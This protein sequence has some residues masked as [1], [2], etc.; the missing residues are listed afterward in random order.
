[1]F[2]SVLNKHRR[3][4]PG[5]QNEHASAEVL[6]VCTTVQCPS[7]I[8]FVPCC[9]LEFPGLCLTL[10]W[11]LTLGQPCS[12]SVM[13][14]TAKLADS[15]GGTAAW[16]PTY[17]GQAKYVWSRLTICITDIFHV[18][19]CVV[20]FWPAHH[21]LQHSVHMPAQHNH[22]ASTP[23][24]YQQTT[25]GLKGQGPVELGD[26]RPAWANASCCLRPM[27]P[28]LSHKSQS[29]RINCILRCMLF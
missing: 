5:V 3:L 10:V 26:A 16:H 18:V 29:R 24:A 14:L 23:C 20:S 22:G 28:P 19:I 7:F 6:V 15:D 12:T 8:A 11:F 13:S 21:Q 4:S 9:V 25:T 17:R 2:C 1:M 27:K